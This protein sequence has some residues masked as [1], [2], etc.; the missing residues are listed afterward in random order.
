MLNKKTMSLLAC[1]FSAAA[2]ASGDD[3]ELI[4]GINIIRKWSS[5]LPPWSA[6]WSSTWSS[7]GENSRATGSSG[8]TAGFL[9]PNPSSYGF[10]IN[11]NFL[12]FETWNRECL[13]M[14]SIFKLQ[15][16]DKIQN[17][18]KNWQNTKYW[19]T[20]PRPRIPPPRP[21]R[22]LET[23]RSCTGDHFSRLVFLKEVDA[24]FNF[25][26]RR[27]ISISCWWLLNCG[28]AENALKIGKRGHFNSAAARKRVDLRTRTL[29]RIQN[30]NSVGRIWKLFPHRSLVHDWWNVEGSLLQNAFRMVLL[31]IQVG[32]RGYWYIG[33]KNLLNLQKE[34]QVPSCV[35]L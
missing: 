28:E 5:L 23:P 13:T 8:S 1:A 7:Q 2:L 29:I 21:P 22:V 16:I 4:F 12:L 30:S 32:I 15:N 6:S 31:G 20:P 33:H 18:A 26:A 35:A 34:K 14:R 3:L 9:G 10:K 24:V 25:L 11:P 17:I 19:L 27:T